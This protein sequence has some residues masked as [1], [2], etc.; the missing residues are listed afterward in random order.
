MEGLFIHVLNISITAS[1]LVLAIIFY[2]LFA[3]IQSTLVFT[4]NYTDILT[5]FA[6]LAFIYFK[7]ADFFAFF[8]FF[9]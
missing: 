6:L 3:K 7:N 2:R 8:Y 5:K 9:F 1:F 4:I